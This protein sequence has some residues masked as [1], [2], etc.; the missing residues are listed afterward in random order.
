[1]QN[2]LR[3]TIPLLHRGYS[4]K[5]LVDGF[6]AFTQN[7]DALY[8]VTGK[9]Q[10][11]QPIYR[12]I[13]LV[14]QLQAGHSGGASHLLYNVAGVDNNVNVKVDS[15]VHFSQTAPYAFQT[16]ITPFRGHRQ[17]TLFGNQYAVW[18]T[19]V[20]FP[21]FQTLIPIETPLSVVN[22]LQLGLFSDI[23]TAKET[24]QKPQ[25]KNG[26]FWSYGMSARSKLAGYPIRVDVA[27]PG[28]F[29][30]NPLWYFSLSTQ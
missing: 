23:A 24:W 9:V 3:P 11:H 12:Y 16:L 8:G 22:S 13:T 20:Y 28:T 29:S 25:V 5:L 6:K 19:D 30:K 14:A 2:K 1:M 21:L 26:L 10:Y 17:N 18:N 7:G 15:T 4:A 27:W